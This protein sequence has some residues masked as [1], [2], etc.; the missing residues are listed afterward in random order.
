MVCLYA[1]ALL[2]FTLSA[3]EY[4]TTNV[5]TKPDAFLLEPNPCYTVVFH[6]CSFKTITVPR[7]NF[8]TV[9]YAG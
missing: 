2:T 8:L 1:R 9:Y 3:S 6:M 4:V 5:I 7:K